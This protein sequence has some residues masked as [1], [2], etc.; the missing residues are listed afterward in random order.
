[1]RCL[2]KTPCL[3]SISHLYMREIYNYIALLSIF[4]LSFGV[5]TL[6]CFSPYRLASTIIFKS[7]GAGD[8]SAVLLRFS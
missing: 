3:L 2:I 8:P 1:M 6:I 5:L 4:S 7:G